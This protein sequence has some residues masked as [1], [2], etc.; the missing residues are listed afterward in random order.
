MLWEWLMYRFMNLLVFIALYSALDEIRFLVFP[1]RIKK[2]NSGTSMVSRESSW[3][4]VLQAN[5]NTRAR[6]GIGDWRG[7]SFCISVYLEQEKKKN[8]F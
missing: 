3:R 7:E 2:P 5:A 8:T 4:E 1:R 6:A